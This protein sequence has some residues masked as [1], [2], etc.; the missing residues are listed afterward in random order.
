MTARKWQNLSLFLVALAH[1]VSPNSP[2]PGDA[3]QSPSLH[4]TLMILIIPS[5]SATPARAAIFF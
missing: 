3:V 4:A 1:C 5:S 2:L